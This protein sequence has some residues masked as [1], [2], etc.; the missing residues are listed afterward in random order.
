MTP[1]K[2]YSIANFDHNANKPPLDVVLNRKVSG[3]K[4]RKAK[5]SMLVS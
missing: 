3:E 5:K 4:I 2:I 1:M